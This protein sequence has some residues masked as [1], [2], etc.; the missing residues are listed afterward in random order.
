MKHRDAAGDA[1]ES[2]LVECELPDPPEKV[3]HALTDRA[4]VAAWLMPNTLG[5]QSERFRLTPEH[6]AAG[7]KA[8]VIECEVVTAR[9]PELLR[10]TWRHSVDVRDPVTSGEE[11]PSRV[12]DSLVTF[13]LSRTP[14]GGTHLRLTH[15]G[16]AIVSLLPATA[17]ASARA[18]EITTLIPF[19]S[20]TIRL[21]RRARRTRT[22]TSCA[23]V[24]RTLMRAA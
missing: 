5:E 1:N 10:Y 18:P 23:S 17:P 14:S 3:W 6:A 24:M 2:V 21:A 20:R 15:N 22:I 8:P 7:Q 16:F 12:L 9:P 11:T 19:R 13:E 4:L